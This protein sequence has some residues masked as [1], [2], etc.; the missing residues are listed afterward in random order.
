MDIVNI[1]PII[2][3][4]VDGAM[5]AL[6]ANQYLKTRY[7]P[8]LILLLHYVC[9]ISI[10]VLWLPLSF[11]GIDQSDPARFLMIGMIFIILSFP[12]FTIAFFEST[13]KGSLSIL[14]MSFI[15]YY[16]FLIGYSFSINWLFV[17]ERIWRYQIGEN[18]LILFIIP[19]AGVVIY[20]V[21]R[22]L[23]II[24]FLPKRE[25][26]KNHQVSGKMP[27]ILLLV[28]TGGLLLRYLSILFLATEGVSEFSILI[29]ILS[30]FTI[31]LVFLFNPSTF[32][33]SNARIQSFLIFEAQSG[34]LLYSMVGPQDDLR[35]SGLHGTSL[36]EREIT[37]ASSM[38]QML[39]FVDRVVLI[40]Y[41]KIHDK[42]LAA[43][44]IVTKNNPVFI[45]SLNYGLHLFI[46]TFPTEIKN[47]NAD[48]EVFKNFTVKAT[49]IFSYA[50]ST[51]LNQSSAEKKQ[52]Q[53]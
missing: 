47:W 29:L 24:F 16:L 36:L 42:L 52:S 23:R 44:M 30:V 46:K 19:F 28:W 27:N 21:I 12:C 31:A 51:E 9:F 10:H 22:L 7:R 3:L 32:F 13:G 38:P 8:S 2:G 6:I 43:A 14:L 18:V 35:A 26:I 34:N 45:P 1:F 11:M 48:R 4:F 15:F 53:R 37:G 39:I 5:I 40:Q 49:K 50:Y 17:F 20:I 25:S 41:Q 33:L